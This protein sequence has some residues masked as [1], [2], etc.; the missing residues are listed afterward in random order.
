METDSL[1]FA[2]R[3]KS[4]RIALLIFVNDIQNE[5]SAEERERGEKKKERQTGEK[6]RF[7]IE[8]QNQEMQRKL[9]R[10]H[11]SRVMRFVFL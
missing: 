6:D 4:E 5:C 8:G 9:K 2:Y 1:R 3:A 11:R 10:T 7:R